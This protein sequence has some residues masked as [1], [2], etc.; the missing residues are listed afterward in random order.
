MTYEV[1][2]E[3]IELVDQQFAHIDEYLR[4]PWDGR[5]FPIRDLAYCLL[6]SILKEYQHLKSGYEK[7]TALEA[8]ACRNLLELDVYVKYILASETNAKRFIGHIAIDGI[9]IFDSMKKWMK[10]VDPTVDRSGLDE[11]LR[12]LEHFRFKCLHIRMRRRS[13]S[14]RLA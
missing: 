14:I 6:V 9:E 8:W 12:L 2:V 1:S 10:Q 13:L 3:E 11:N 4:A 5:D 7:D